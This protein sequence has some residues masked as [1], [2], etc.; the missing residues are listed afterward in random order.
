MRR[1]GLNKNMADGEDKVAQ[2]LA[3]AAEAREVAATMADPVLRATM[4]KIAQG[5]ERMARIAEARRK[6]SS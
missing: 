4:L 2:W 3:L 6:N 1:K 5:Y